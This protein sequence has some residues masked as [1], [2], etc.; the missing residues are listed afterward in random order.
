MQKLL[1]LNDVLSS[2]PLNRLHQVSLSA[3][4]QSTM[5]NSLDSTAAPERPPTPPGILDILASQGW[6]RYQWVLSG[7]GVHCDVNPDYDSESGE[8]GCVP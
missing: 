8:Y 4:F 3:H 2:E 1:E 6:A 5:S 7:P